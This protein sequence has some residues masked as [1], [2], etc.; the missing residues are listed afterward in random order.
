MPQVETQR[1][2]LLIIDGSKLI[3]KRLMSILK[4]ANPL[5]LILTALNYNE[6]I[7]ILEKRKTDIVLLDIQLT[8]KRGIELLHFI[9]K[10]FPDIRVIVQTN[11]ISDY[12]QNLCKKAGAEHFIDKSRDF[13]KIPELIAAL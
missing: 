11:L 8:D 10:Q 6:A 5:N 2:L 13:D 1:K 7:E 12:Y 9:K 3:L 4:E